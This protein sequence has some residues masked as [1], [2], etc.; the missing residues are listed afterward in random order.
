MDSKHCAYCGKKIG[1]RKKKLKDG[2]CLCPRCAHKLPPFIGKRLKFYDMIEYRDALWLMTAGQK[3][4]KRLFKKTKAFGKV[5]FDME[6]HMI[7]VKW[8]LLQKTLYF[9]LENIYSF[10]SESQQDVTYESR[11]L[12]KEINKD[13]S[14]DADGYKEYNSEHYHDKAVSS[15]WGTLT[16]I[17]PSFQVQCWMFSDVT[18]V[19]RDNSDKN[20][21]FRIYLGQALQKAKE[22]IRF[23]TPHSFDYQKQFDEFL[24][25]SKER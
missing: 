10:D 17:Y 7:R 24:A 23:G 16:H 15:F 19:D 20:F 5:A 4:L 6:H 11:K 2:N 12:K 14:Y 8:G 3:E 21:N 1:L 9:R 13:Y 18:D 22:E 25:G